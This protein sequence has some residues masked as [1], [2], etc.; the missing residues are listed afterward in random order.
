MN[1]YRYLEKG[2]TIEAGDEILTRLALPRREWQ[3]E[4]FQANGLT[5]RVG[6]GDYWQE[7]EVRRL[8]HT[9]ED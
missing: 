1:Q 9:E 5:Y 2:E 3:W 6:M 8:I 4:S 7:G